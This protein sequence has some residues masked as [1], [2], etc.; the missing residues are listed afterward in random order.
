MSIW[1]EG[2][3]KRPA[4]NARI[5]VISS[6]NMNFSSL[7]RKLRL[8]SI[9]HHKRMLGIA[10]F[11]FLLTVITYFLV[12]PGPTPHNYFARLAQSFINLRLYTTEAPSYLNELVPFEGKYYVA[13]PPMPAVI[14]V[15]WITL[16]NQNFSE[17]YFSIILAGFNV[18]LAYY[19]IRKLGFSQRTAVF[20]A[21]FFGFG[22]N[23]VF[24]ASVGSSWYIA[25][26][27]SLFFLLLA[28]IETV[29][30]KR[31]ILIG[32]LIGMSFWSRTSVLFTLPFFY[33]YLWKD[34]WPFKTSGKNLNIT[35]ISN[36][37]LLNLGLIIFISIDAIYNYARFGEFS[38]FA[39][40][41]LIQNVDP[42]TVVN[43]IY[44]SIDYIPRHIDALIFRLPKIISSFPYLIPSL[45]ATAIWFTSPVLIYI[46][47]VRKSLL[48]LACWLGILPTL[49]I[50]MQWAGVGFSQFGYRFAQ[51]FM[52]LLLILVALGVGK[53]PSIFAYLLLTISI[54]VNIWGTIVINKLNLYFM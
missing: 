10:S 6:L 13:L 19:L 42:N 2:K 45:Y 50:V 3:K 33:I 15:P 37:F 52:P 5:R 18:V 9:I 35:N 23:Q 28:L 20:T 11:L 32:I 29:T 46:F 24:L 51:D 1:K 14:M 54:L 4:L 34:L 22:T 49:F 44:M 39:P 47:K 8:S 26:I 31:L 7:E 17:T 21:L 40:Y 48:T 41:H 27:V 12:S 38:P 43:G 25:H 36:L 53:K 16:F 30:K